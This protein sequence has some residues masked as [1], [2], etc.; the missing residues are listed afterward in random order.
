MEEQDRIELR[1]EDVQ[2]ILGTPPG[3]LVRWG[4]LVVLLAVGALL[5]VSWFLEYPDVVEAEVT[6]TTTVPPVEVVARTDG[7]ID[8]FL[9]N[10]QSS[11]KAGDLLVVLKST[12]DF[13]Q[14]QRLDRLVDNWQQAG[15]NGTWETIETPY[16]LQI[17]E[18]QPA[19]ST[20]IQNLENFRFG[21]T[22]RAPSVTSNNSGVYQ[23]ISRLN[24]S[25][26]DDERNKTRLKSQIDTAQAQYRR[27]L[28]SGVLSSMELENARTHIDDIQ[29][30]YDEANEAIIRKQNEILLLRRSINDAS[31]DRTEDLTA[32]TV[33]LRESLQALRSALDR[34][35]QTYLLTAPIDGRVALN[36]TYFSASQ[37]VKQGDQVLAIVPPQNNQIIGRLLLPIEGSGKVKPGQQ[38][39]IKLESYPYPEYGAVLGIV[40]SKSLVP[41]D[42]KYSIVVEPELTADGRLKTTFGKPVEFEQQLLGKAEIVTE[43]KRFLERVT[44][45]VFKGVR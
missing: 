21:T 31:L 5:A 6:L 2:E 30:G 10:E 3:W 44:E 27:G 22:R 28:Q 34:W 14:V 29:R 24:T 26:A 12:A 39:Y 16:N 41:K 15:N 13:L 8:S 19:Y 9:V 36:S 42:K 33:Q 25:I 17:G 1:S 40:R 37:Y 35:K 20:F 18:V 38:V 7:H 45:Q 43:K 32:S 4:T 11:V 23:Q